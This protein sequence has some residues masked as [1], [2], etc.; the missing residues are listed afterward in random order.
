[1]STLKCASSWESSL[2]FYDISAIVRYLM[3]NPVYTYISNIYDLQTHFVDNIF[4]RVWVNLF[5]HS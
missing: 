2:R 3:P 5:L 1:M 4:K